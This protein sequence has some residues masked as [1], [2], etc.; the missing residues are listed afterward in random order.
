MPSR[1]LRLSAL[2]VTVAAASLGLAG[3]THAKKT[4]PEQVAAQGY[5]AALASG[6][7]GGAAQLTSDPSAAL[8][9]IQQSL[10]GL[11]VGAKATL[12]VTGLVDRQDAGATANYT[13][14][15]TLPG[16]S[17]PWRYS[18]SLPVVKR[19]KAWVVS[20]RSS[21]VYPQLPA[22]SHLSVQRTQPTRAALQ[23][24]NGRPLFTKT[25][26][27]EVGINPANVD[28]LPSLATTLAAVP[29]LQTTASE[30]TA[31]VKAAP[32]NQFVPLIALRQNVYLQI[33]SKIYDLKGTQFNP[34]SLL[35]PP[36]SNFAKPLLGSVGPATKE[37]VDASKGR[38][39]AGDETGLSGLQL[40]L[41]QQ[42]SGTPGVAVYAAT[43]TG[44]ALGTKLATLSTAA[45]GKPIRLT[46]DTALQEAADAT[47]SGVSLPAAL[48]A[49]QPSTGKILAVANSA[50]ATEDIALAGQYPAG[51]TFKIITYTAAFQ[52]DPALAA[53]STAPCPATVTVDGRSF[54]NEKKFAHGTVPLTAAFGYSCNTTAISTALTLPPGA[55]HRAATQLGLGGT[56]KLPVD[57]F[58]GSLPATATGTELAA[59]AIGQGKVLV[60]PLAMASVAGAAATGKPVAPSLLPEP[61]NA[62]GAPLAAKVTSNLNALLRAT[63]SMPGATGYADLNDLPGEIRGKTGTAEFGTD[64]PPKSHSW[65]AGSRA[66][67]AIAVFVYGGEDSTTGAVPLARKFF[68]SAP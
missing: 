17:T 32:K 34:S 5:L 38:V 24:R 56:W 31:A 12:A 16:V 43:S 35:L 36:T 14:S 65:F 60:S 26:V 40:A 68:T 18:G 48:V 41:D 51:S 37:L 3:C 19:G 7:A 13:A 42:L 62:S 22:G 6:N 23:D 27:V 39:R 63:V 15:W 11:G 20:W 47:L 10:Q 28:D 8:P 21:D 57:Y 52:N 58:S 59:E 1:R 55:L 53:A 25:P 30:I 66:D 50:A 33:K 9:T 49:L 45:A 61:A 2:A 67:L 54:E 64:T 46:L 44:E 29:Q 4:P